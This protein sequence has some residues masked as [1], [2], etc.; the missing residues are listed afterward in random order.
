MQYIQRNACQEGGKS[1]SRVASFLGSIAPC[2]APVVPR[3]IHWPIML[4]YLR[5]RDH[6]P[7][8]PA[9]LDVSTPP[10]FTHTSTILL[11][12]APRTIRLT[13]PW[14]QDGT[15]STTGVGRSR[16]AGAHAASATRDPYGDTIGGVCTTKMGLGL[17]ARARRSCGN[18]F[19]L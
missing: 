6:P 3:T 18:V 10:P 16:G 7:H 5:R 14:C 13:R 15:Y 17:L 9:A 19:R 1:L 8:K 12:P 11:I 4:V 2:H